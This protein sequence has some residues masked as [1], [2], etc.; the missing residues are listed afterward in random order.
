[1]AAVTAATDIRINS[2]S[3]VGTEIVQY[4][5]TVAFGQP[6]YL[7]T[8]TNT[9]KL[10]DSNNTVVEA[11]LACIAITPGVAGGYGLIARTGLVTYTG[12]TFV[13]G[14][15]YFVGQT[16]GSIIPSA[17][18]TTGDWVQRIGTAVASDTLK[19][20]IEVVGIQHA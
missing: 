10:A 9:Y 18:L 1:M 17:D 3:A 5:A 4:G 8:G 13:V 12:T 11:Q 16:A 20:S 19:L 7:D 15:S 6:L 14:R 2:S